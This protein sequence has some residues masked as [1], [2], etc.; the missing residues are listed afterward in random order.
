D[1]NVPDEA[2]RAVVDALE[3]NKSKYTPAPGIPELREAVARKTNGQQPSVNPPWKGSDVVVTN[4]GKQALLNTFLALLD[5][6]DEVLIPS[7]YW[8]SYPEMVKIAEGTPRILK[9]R[10]EDGFKLKPEQLARAI[11]PKTKILV[12]NS[13][14]NPT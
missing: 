13:P 4:G 11:T 7:P 10:F 1:F 3:K 14:S 9:T 12:L 8:L 6:G 2:K 5:P